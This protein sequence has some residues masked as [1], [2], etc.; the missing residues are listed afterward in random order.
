MLCFPFI[1]AGRRIADVDVSAL[2]PVNG[3]AQKLVD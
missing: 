1:A 3:V 2:K